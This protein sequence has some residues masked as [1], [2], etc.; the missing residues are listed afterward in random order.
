[1]HVPQQYSSYEE[2]K[3][4]QWNKRSEIDFGN[5]NASYAKIPLKVNRGEQYNKTFEDLEPEVYEINVEEKIQKKLKLSSNCLVKSLMMG[6]SINVNP[7]NQNLIREYEELANLTQNTFMRSQLN[8]MNEL[9]NQTLPF[10]FQNNINWIANLINT[11]NRIYLENNSKLLNDL[12]YKGITSNEILSSNKDRMSLDRGFFEKR[13]TTTITDT[14]FGKTYNSK[15]L[16]ESRP[17]EVVQNEMRKMTSI[18]QP[19][20]LK[21]IEE[22]TLRED[23]PKSK[24][25][26]KD[27]NPGGPRKQ[28]INQIKAEFPKPQH[29][30]TLVLKNIEPASKANRSKKGEVIQ[31]KDSEEEIRNLIREDSIG[32]LLKTDSVFSQAQ[33]QKLQE[34]SNI[35]QKETKDPSSSLTMSDPFVS[36]PGNIFQINYSIYVI[37]LKAMYSV[38]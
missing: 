14:E 34:G 36:F 7:M 25:I 9:I 3:Q 38:I 16:Y 12:I 31:Q 26:Q 4:I 28:E 18:A 32:Y 29:N 2:P 30:K 24:V 23:N 21:S 20:P 10:S 22:T 27:K 1:M 33:N 37:H 19:R 11:D 8:N 35:Q 5:N 6:D 15:N 13:M 17:F